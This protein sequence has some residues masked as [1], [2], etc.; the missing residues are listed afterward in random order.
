MC[1]IAGFCGCDGD[2]GLLRRMAAS[3][4]HRGPDDE[5][6]FTA[7][8]VGLAHRRLSIIDLSCGRQPIFNE[9]GDVAIVFNGEIYNYRELKARLE[10]AGHVFST[11]TDTEV[12]VHLY[13][14]VGERFPEQLL[15]MF[16]I[17]L[18]DD[19]NKSLHLVRDHLGKKPL[20]YASRGRALFFA[21]EAKA[22]FENPALTPAVDEEALHFFLNCRWTPG[23]MTLFAGVR[24]LEPGCHLAYA[25]GRFA[26]RRY[27]ELT[28]RT[29]HSLSEA[30]HVERVRE[31]FTRSV[32]RRLMSDV[33]IGV[34]LSAGLDSTAIA[35]V[36][37]RLHSE[38]LITFTVGFNSPEDEL[39]GAQETSRHLG[40]EHH[41]VMMD[42]NPLKYL[43]ETIWFNE[44][45]KVNCIQ[46]YLLA[47][48]A[49]QHVKV[50]LGGLGGD[51]LFGGYDNYMYIKWFQRLH[52]LVPGPARKLLGLF[53]RL[54]FA[55]QA[56][57]GAL[58]FDEL[59]R[60]MQMLLASGN[61]TRYY[62]ILRNVWDGDAPFY[63]SIY[64]PETARRMAGM[65]VERHFQR[66]FPNGPE[67]LL[68]QAMACELQEKIVADQIWLEDRNTMAHSLESRA[69]FLD[70]DLVEHCVNMPDRYKIKGSL[71]KS[72]FIQAMRGIV[73][74]FAFS[75]PKRGFAFNPYLQFKRDLRDVARKVLTRKRIEEQGLFNY[76]YLRRIMDY[77]PQR[78]MQWHYWYLWNMVGFQVWHDLFITRERTWQD[79][80]FPS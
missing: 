35:T 72:V 5:G 6:F 69:P 45:P 24:Q 14:E 66:Y 73:P 19:R 67:T 18:W 47:R 39:A 46:M 75:R 40:T 3:L 78:S 57:S 56:A 11:N 44:I 79:Y 53:S 2:G 30:E 65:G 41:E 25:D 52:N 70:K 62:L 22:L 13:E 42:F 36:M 64:S 76:E 77:P 8:G 29:D 32:E 63:R 10:A 80:E 61:R 68:N 9:A 49:S 31:L 33:P 26:V 15:G 37:S 34:F 4:S 58:R 20:F 55:V 12:I 28:L 74:D 17:A 23:D 71:R 21:S 1:G 27:W 50:A 16:A 38:R 43:P 48:F 51:E 54:L 7:P 60:G 59:R